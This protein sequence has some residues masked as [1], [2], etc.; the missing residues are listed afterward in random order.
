MC[1]QQF[2]QLCTGIHGST[3]LPESGL[4]FSLALSVGEIQM[5]AVDTA[6]KVKPGGLIL[7]CLLV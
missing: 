7:L 5:E 2:G 4:M 1:S 3:C 6:F